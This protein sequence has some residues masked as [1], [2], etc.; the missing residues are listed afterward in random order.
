M[1]FVSA[2]QNFDLWLLHILT[3][4]L[5]KTFKNQ[6]ASYSIYDRHFLC[7]ST[8]VQ[9]LG[10]Q[11]FV[12]NMEINISSWYIHAKFHKSLLQC[13]YNDFKKWKQTKN[14]AKPKWVIFP[15]IAPLQK[16]RDPN[17]LSIKIF[18]GKHFWIFHQMIWCLYAA[19][20]HKFPLY[21]GIPCYLQC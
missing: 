21:L 19:M 3:C 15:I 9:T 2:P 13:S 17:F 16:N 5:K 7:S 8:L 14:S 1:V 20:S 11:I 6:S 10:F 12:L 18:H 4:R